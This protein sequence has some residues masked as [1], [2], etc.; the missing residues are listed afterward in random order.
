MKHKVRAAPSV[1]EQVVEL[2]SMTGGYPN[3]G[4]IAD[5]V[6]LSHMD[7]YAHAPTCHACGVSGSVFKDW[8]EYVNSPTHNYD[9]RLACTKYCDSCMWGMT[10]AIRNVP[11]KSNRVCPSIV[12]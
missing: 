12:V 8:K 9:H 3:D 5:A 4:P 6:T 1:D 7:P 10:R 11:G 2:D